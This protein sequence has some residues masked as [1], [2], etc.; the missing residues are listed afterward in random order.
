MAIWNWLKGKKTYTAAIGL[1][2]LAV[3]YCTTDPPQYEQAVQAVLAALATLG[4][5]NAISNS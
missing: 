1:V 4:I 3:Y 5:R 2:C